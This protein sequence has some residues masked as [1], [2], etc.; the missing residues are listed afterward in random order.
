MPFLHTELGFMEICLGKHSLNLPT[1]AVTIGNFDGVHLG[2]KHILQRLSHEA[3]ARGLRSVAVI[4]EPQ[5]N[6]FFSQQMG[7]TPSLRLSPLRD[8]L[9]LLAQTGCLNAVRVL[10]FNPEFAN[11]SADDFIERILRQQ[12]NTRYLLVGDDFRFGKGRAGDFELLA[13]QTDFI[14]ERTPSILVAGERAS[15]T[16]VRQALRDGRLDAARQIL[17][18]DY[19]LSGRVK[20]GKKLGRTLGSPTANVHLPPHHYA[21]RGVFVVE[22]SGSFGRRRGVASLGYNPTVSHEKRSQLEVHLFNFSGDLYG[23]RIEV[24]FLHKLRDEQKFAD[25][26]SLQAQIHLDMAQARAWQN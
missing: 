24:A 9:R 5:P 4:F 25:L 22:V 13:Q 12:L 11:H 2:H 10:R 6:E 18:H 14:T 23:E 1:S 26:A 15:S 17:G 16:A 21:L 19:V 7:K 8:K 20:H 3:Q